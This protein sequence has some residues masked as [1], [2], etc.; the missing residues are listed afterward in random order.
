LEI[1]DRHGHDVSH[2]LPSVNCSNACVPASNSES[3]TREA[4]R[5]QRAAMAGLGDA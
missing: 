2:Q 4:H 3:A 5:H 1:K